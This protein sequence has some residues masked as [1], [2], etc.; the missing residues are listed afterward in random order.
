M[1]CCNS[2]KLSWGGVV[3]ILLLTVGFGQAKLKTDQAKSIYQY[4]QTSAVPLTQTRVHKIGNMWLSI[5]NFGQIGNFGRGNIDLCTGLPAPSCEFPAG[6]GIDY[7]FTGAL[8]IGAVVNDID[9]LVS[10]GFDGWQSVQ[11]FYPTSTGAISSRTIRAEGYQQDNCFTPYSDSAVSE[12]DY[13]AVYYDTITDAA[14]VGP[15]P[16]DGPHHPLYLEVTQKSYSWSYEY[17]NDFI[18]FD[19]LIKNIGNAKLNQVYLGFYVDFD[20][21]G[22]EFEGDGHFDD[23]AGFKF[24]VPSPYDP[25]LED[26]VN[27][28]WGADNDGLSMHRWE[29]DVFKDYVSPT[30]VIGTRVIRSPNPDLKHSFNWWVSNG[31]PG[32]DFGPWTQ[33]NQARRPNYFVPNG[34]SGTP[35]S[36]RAKY[37]IMSNNET[38]YDQL[39]AALQD[40]W[41]R[42]GWVRQNQISP[43][44]LA[45]IAEGFDSRYLLSFGPFDID[46]GET[47]PLTIAFVAGEDFHVRPT[48]MV[49]VDFFDSASVFDFYNKLDFTSLVANAHWAACVYDN[50][51]KD[52]DGDG[53][54]GEFRIIDGDTIYK[55]GDGIPDFRGPPPPPA[56]SLDF[57]TSY[58]TVKI[59]WNGK[60]TEKFFDQF[61]NRRDFEGYRIYG[62][63]TGVLGDFFLLDSF[64]KMNYKFFYWDKGRRKWAYKLTDLSTDSLIALFQPDDPCGGTRP[65]PLE[66]LA[67][68]V[69]P[70]NC[71]DGDVMKW[72][73]YH[74]YI[75]KGTVS[76]TLR[77]APNLFL[78]KGDSLYFDRQ[79]YN[80]GLLPI[81]TYGDSIETGK[82]GSDD[83]RYYDYEYIID[84]LNPNYPLYFAV[85][86]FDFGDP[87]TRL[88]PLETSVLTTPTL[89]YPRTC[90]ARPADVN[91]D[92]E[93]L[94]SDIVAMINIR[95]KGAP[96][97]QPLCR[98]DING[99]G[100][101]TFSDIIYFVNFLFRGG[102]EPPPVKDCCLIGN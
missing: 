84:N 45:D 97:P 25:R 17:A 48:D 89:V 76:D 62:S 74:P 34:Q 30:G 27:V 44:N 95:F 86:T 38:D 39:F 50:P 100:G 91:G 22:F 2:Y 56:P 14:N 29:G 81:K 15:D 47:L 35:E 101:I 78:I 60:T 31:N 12:L 6:S 8:W 5:T 65:C 57:E 42:Q 75:Y 28:A 70:N 94:L 40:M 58:G 93:V 21:H 4:P 72:T 3:I 10:V 24:S 33:Q 53:Y 63:W 67:F 102:P 90:L 83:D 69:D 88:A 59:K 26:T 64:D 46:S 99:N 36:D 37:F 61:T 79:D 66:S 13:V 32:L 18:L 41:E 52:T 55:C 19:F 87:I 9:T 80:R 16:L 49:G 92:G 43:T 98:L 54:K 82:I 73:L 20:V 85:T 11:E 68:C 96:F 7:L 1:R 77:I 51:G 23:I 71:D